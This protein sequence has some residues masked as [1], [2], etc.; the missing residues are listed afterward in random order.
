MSGGVA[1]RECGRDGRSGAIHSMANALASSSVMRRTLTK[2]SHPLRAARP[3][4]RRGDP[5]MGEV[6]I[7]SKRTNSLWGASM[8]AEI[9]L[10]QSKRR[11][12]RP[13]R[14]RR[15]SAWRTSAG[16]GGRFKRGN[17]RRFGPDKSRPSFI[18]SSRRE[19]RRLGNG[20]GWTGSPPPAPPVPQ[21]EEGL[22]DLSVEGG[23]AH[24][25]AA[26]QRFPV[27]RC[28]PK[29]GARSCVRNPARIHE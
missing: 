12:G 1:H 8:S 15:T 9:R 13:R 23:R 22:I 16:T 6:M 27:P 28:R 29:Q 5:T 3:E 21:S 11:L 19:I 24:S 14:G 26:L 2:R 10:R 18:N 17:S 20:R 7:A 25:R 4:V